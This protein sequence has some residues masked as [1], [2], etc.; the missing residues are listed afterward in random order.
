QQQVLQAIMT[1]IK[2]DNS[3]LTDKLSTYVNLYNLFQTDVQTNVEIKDLAGVFN[4]VSKISD[5]YAS[6]VVD[7]DLDGGRIVHYLGILPGVGWSIGFYDRSGNQLRNYLANVSGNIA[8]Y[9]EKPKIKIYVNPAST[10]VP[11]IAAAIGGGLGFVQ[12]N[13][14]G[15]WPTD[16]DSLTGVRIYDFSGGDKAG[17]I[18]ELQARLPGSRI[19]SPVIDGLTRSEWGEEIVVIVG[20]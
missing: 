2:N 19:Y 4:L 15:P 11:D 8:F 10:N 3:S 12:N 17:S 16:L 6:V 5:A 18:K 14:D 9:S 7:Q 13:G 1:E 20:L